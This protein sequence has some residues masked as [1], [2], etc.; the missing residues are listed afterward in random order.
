M[1]VL[2]LKVCSQYDDNPFFFRPFSFLTS[3][4]KPWCGITLFPGSQHTANNYPLRGSKACCKY[5]CTS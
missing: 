5:T 1:A 2:A 3:L 4:R